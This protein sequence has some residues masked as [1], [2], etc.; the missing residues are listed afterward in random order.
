MNIGDRIHGCPT[1]SALVFVKPNGHATVITYSQLEERIDNCRAWLRE[2]G[3][4]R[5]D[6]LA[7]LADNSDA[8]VIAWYAALREGLAVVPVN[9]KLLLPAITHIIKDSGAVGVLVDQHHADKVPACFLSAAITPPKAGLQDR[10]PSQI[11]EN[12]DRAVVLYTSGSTGMP[13]GVPMDH[14]GYNWT[15]DTRL[16]GDVHHHHRLLVAAPLYHINALGAV[17]FALAAGACVVLLQRFEAKVYLQAIE[18]HRCTWLTSVPAM[19]A[20]VVRESEA[21]SETDLSSVQSVRMG[22]SPVSDKLFAQVR[23][24]FGE[25]VVISN[26]YGTTEGGPLVFGA[27]PEGKQPPVGSVGW[28]LV[29]VHAKL[30][31][32]QG[33]E[34]AECGELVHKTP[35]TMKGYLNLPDKTQQVLSTDGWYSTGDIFRRD[36][37]GAYWFVSRVDDMF[38]CGGENL[39]P[40]EVERVLEMHADVQQVCVV[41]IADEIKGAKPVAFIV[42]HPGAEVSAEELKLYA[43]SNGPSYQHP[44]HIFFVDQLPLAGTNKI[45]RKELMKQAQE[46]LE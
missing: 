15:I 6:S 36:E 33:N 29:G 16:K 40:Q 30:V 5:G 20:M 1:N 14:S 8:F 2:L 45:D 11:M 22:S 46:N 34:S 44:R 4:T 26:A 28:P 42:K 23:A 19:L 9:H 27:S 3:F 25:H 38:V 31:D 10:R 41:P 37:Q 17:T 24:V 43:L 35:A 32:A 39:H 18:R 21:L 7:L 13:K 12:A